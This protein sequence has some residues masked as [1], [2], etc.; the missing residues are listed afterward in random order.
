MKKGTKVFLAATP[1]LMSMGIVVLPTHMSAKET[2]TMTINSERNTD[3]ES[4]VSADGAC[5]NLV[6]GYYADDQF[7]VNGL[8]NDVVGSDGQQFTVYTP[9][10]KGE[11][12][13]TVNTILN[14]KPKPDPDRIPK[15]EK[16][17]NSK[18]ESDG[19][20]L[21]KEQKDEKKIGQK[22][23]HHSDSKGDSS[24]DRE[25]Q[26]SKGQRGLENQ[27]VNKNNEESKRNENNSEKKE[28]KQTSSD[29]EKEKRSNSFFHYIIGAAIVALGLVGGVLW[30]RKKA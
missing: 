3:F 23:Q 25:S 5:S 12:T 22:A 17:E 21:D 8:V 11:T 19:S 4:A 18:I 15:P 9:N 7:V 2:C 6:Y 10:G 28:V 27:K 16:E 30:Y 29:S 13:L 26:S 24:K 1:I 20:H 14:S